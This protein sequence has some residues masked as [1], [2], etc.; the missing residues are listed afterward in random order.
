[1]ERGQAQ[2]SGIERLSV[3]R[4][5]A[6]AVAGLAACA[7]A[8]VG[9]AIAIYVPIYS[10][11]GPADRDSWT[12]DF[13]ARIAA[14]VALHQVLAAVTWFFIARWVG[15]PRLVAAALILPVILLLT[16]PVVGFLTMSNP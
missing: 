9:L 5:A 10:L 4:T 14:G 3:A 11:P 13:Y 7:V 12:I 2:P 6:K 8:Y 16:L 1:M 15:L